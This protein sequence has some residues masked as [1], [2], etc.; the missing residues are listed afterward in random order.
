[1][2]T[3]YLAKI[4][5]K[6]SYRRYWLA[7]SLSA[8]GFELLSF[9]L[10]VV[11]FD[12]TRKAVS[13]GAF[14]AIYM[15]CLVVFGP[16]AGIYIDRWNR[17]KI[18]I[19]C[20]LLLALLISSLNFFTGLLWIYFSWFLA[21][22]FLV[23]LRPARVALITNLF[24]EE[25]YLQ[26]NSAFMMSLNFSKIGGPLIGG[27]LLIYFSR[28]WTINLILFF[29]LISSV[30]ASTIAF[31]QPQTKSLHQEPSK[32]TWGN[33]ASGIRF[34]LSQE[35]LRFYISIGLL[36]RFF[37]ASQLPLYIVFV[38]DYLGGGTR[39]YSIFM[40]V[41]SAGGAVGALLA[42]GMGNRFSRKTMIYGG[43]GASY[44]LFAL[45]PLSQS[46]LFAL[47][48]IGLSNLF[49]FIAHVAIH[50]DIQR[51]TPNEIRGSVFASSPTLF[52]PAGLISILIATPLADA[53]GVQWI[54]LFTGLLALLTLPLPGYV[55]GIFKREMR[56]GR[57]TQPV[58]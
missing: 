13:M 4:F 25:D 26:A 31:H 40:T 45:M 54:F 12:I 18:F 23:F 20:N 1:M 8:L 57:E 6:P 9:A 3:T 53:V 42:G 7:Y 35:R 44:L 14:M 24:H 58:G 52:V 36:W 19:V 27:M 38:K 41:L 11:L 28:E 48:L 55:G 30:L 32:R 5:E 47:A 37:L 50:S 22:F 15:F 49:F 51:V 43:L 16:P 39:E 33:L 17:K 10:M 29:F 21:S 46:Y 2:F 56:P 34:I